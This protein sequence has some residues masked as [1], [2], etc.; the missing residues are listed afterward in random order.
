MIELLLTGLIAML[1]IIGT[2]VVL[3]LFIVDALFGTR[4]AKAV[5]MR[6]VSS[7]SPNEQEQLLRYGQEL[8]RREIER[9]D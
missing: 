2:I 4:L 3:P 8:R 7:L 9:R 6:I 1:R 5:F